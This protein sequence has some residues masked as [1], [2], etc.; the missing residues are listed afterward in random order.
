MPDLSECRERLDQID[1]QIMRLLVERQEVSADVAAYKAANGLAVLDRERERAKIQKA[2]ELVPP[3]LSNYATVLQ[4]LLM[5]ASR[6]AQHQLLDDQAGTVSARIRP[7]LGAQPSFFPLGAT[8]ACQGVPG[9]YQQIA[10]DRLFRQAQIS[11]QE[12]FADVFDAVESGAC[13]FGVLPIENSTAGSVNGVYSLLQT[14]DCHIVRTCRLRVDHNLLVLP[15]TTKD[16]IEIV[17]SHEQ[18]LQQCAGYI[19][20]LPHARGHLCKNTAKAAEKVAS[21]GRHDI[22]ALA[23]RDCASLYGLEVLEHSVQDSSSNYTRFACIAKDLVIYPGADRTS[24]VLVLSHE[25]GS[26]FKVLAKFY[27][28][29]INIIKLE[30]RP[31]PNRDFEFMFYFDIEY[32]AA[33]PR[34]LELLDAL[35]SSCEEFR[36]LGSYQEVI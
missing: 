32:P 23:S 22:A 7:A 27:A 15:G 10:A 36:Y 17:Y 35:E 11:Y 29:G 4:T 31:I 9:A 16:D 14:H 13:Q 21:S 28:L 3:E 33:A 1:S 19:A 2:T 6:D 26:L 34:F 5:E 20:S 12:S 25:P 24:L 18:A 30:S 8:V